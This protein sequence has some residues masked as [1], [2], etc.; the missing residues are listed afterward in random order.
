MKWYLIR[1]LGNITC[2]SRQ[3]LDVISLNMGDFIML[4]LKEC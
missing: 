3:Q 2:K 1:G 4:N